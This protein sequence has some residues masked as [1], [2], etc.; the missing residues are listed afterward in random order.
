MK[1]V[2]E[3]RA[4]LFDLT[5][6]RLFEVAADRFP[7]RFGRRLRRFAHGP[8]VFKLDWA[9][10]GPVP[11]TAEPCRRAGTVHLGGTLEELAAAEAEV[12][13]GRHPER[14]YVLIAQASLFDRSRAPAGKHT[15]WGYCHVPNGST[16]DMTNAIESQVERFAPGFKD[17]ILARSVMNPADMEAYNSNYMGGDMSGGLQDLR[18]MFTRPSARWNLYTTPD[19]AIYIC[20]SSTPPGGGVHGMCGYHAARA[21]L[22]RTF[23]KT[24]AS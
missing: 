4:T 16:F 1:D 3:A 10:D 14:P 2:P 9:L 23:R 19:D 15:L 5:P 7:A 13:Y 20:S 11:W 17:L 24:P 6:R 22:K 12:A 18:R 8:G 21:A